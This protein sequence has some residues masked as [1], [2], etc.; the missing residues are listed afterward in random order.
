MNDVCLKPTIKYGGGSF[1][2]RGCLTANV[3]A[4]LVRID[5]IMNAAKYLQILVLHATASVK[6]LIGN[7]FIFQQGHYPIHTSRKA[8]SYLESKEQ[9]WYVQVTKWL[10][11]SPNLNIIESLW[12]YLDQRKAETQPKSKEHLW[13]VVQDGWNNILMDYIIKLG[14]SIPKM[15]K[16]CSRCKRWTFKILMILRLSNVINIILILIIYYIFI[17]YHR[18]PF[19][20]HFFY[21]YMEFLSNMPNSFT[22]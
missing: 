1:M 6:R 4:D 2:V 11:K 9:S 14:L 10:L 22:Q 19:F 18:T 21:L 7:G 5:G 8:K 12:H 17:Y 16:C 20:F 15:N 13:Q 3:V